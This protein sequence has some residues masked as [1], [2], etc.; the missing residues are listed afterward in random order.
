MEHDEWHFPNYLYRWDMLVPAQV[1][2]SL[3]GGEGDG[4]LDAVPTW[5]LGILWIRGMDIS[6]SPCPNCQ[7]QTELS[8][9]ILPVSTTTY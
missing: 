5:C 1:S 6:P 3:S 8:I 2:L 7:F 9:K 4:T